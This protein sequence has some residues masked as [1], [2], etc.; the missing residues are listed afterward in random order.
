[1][2]PYFHWKRK[3]ISLINIISPFTIR[4]G[5]RFAL[6]HASTGS[7]EGRGREGGAGH[8]GVAEALHAG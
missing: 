6:P 8:G 4:S 2:P 1:M 5:I 7:R 3:R